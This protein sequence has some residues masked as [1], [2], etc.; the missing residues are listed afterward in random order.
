MSRKKKVYKAILHGILAV[1]ALIMMFP[2]LWMVST[3]FKDNS[4]VFEYP[5]KLIPNPLVLTNYVNVFVK[6]PIVRSFFNSLFIAVINTAGVLL[7]S[8]MAAYS[9]ARLRFRFKGPLFVILL[10]TMMIPS[11]VTLI[12][13]FVW[14]KNLGWYDT[15]YPLILPSIFCNAYG[16]FLLRQFFATIPASY[17][18]SAQLD[19]CSYPVIYAK[20]MLPMCVPAMVTLGIFTF[21]GNWNSFLSPLIYLNSRERFTLP[22]T[23]MSF[24]NLYYSDWGLLMAASCVSIVPV[25]I[26]YI[27]AQKYFTEGIVMSGIKG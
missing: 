23:I 13:M 25:I 22:L 19:G 18:E 7:T 15:Y 24:Q 8:S 10:A 1:I 27:F 17:A 16:V 9:F 5:P 3:S 11:Q 20:I 6:Q 12:P 21:L 2:F 4:S 14:F 26:L